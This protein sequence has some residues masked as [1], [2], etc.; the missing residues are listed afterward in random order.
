MSFFVFEEVVFVFVF[1]YSSVYFLVLIMLRWWVLAR[2]ITVA[3]VGI[4]EI[5]LAV[6][7]GVYS[8]NI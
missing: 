4:M 1:G 7:I 3:C 5:I 2:I 6:V 8:D